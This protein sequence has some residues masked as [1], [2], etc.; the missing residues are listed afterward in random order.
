MIY[1]FS[2]FVMMLM[3]AFSDHQQVKGFKGVGSLQLQIRAIR[4]RSW[5]YNKFEM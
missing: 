2:R 5:C 1:K 3:K 4:D